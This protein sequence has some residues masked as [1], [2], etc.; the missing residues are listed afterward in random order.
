MSPTYLINGIVISQAT[1][2]LV[3][4][5][6][7]GDVSVRVTPQTRIGTA[8]SPATVSVSNQVQVRIAKDT[9]GAS[10]ALSIEVEPDVV[11]I[12]GVVQTIGA[13]TLTVRNAKGDTT[14]ALD[15]D[16]IVV[17]GG[18]VATAAGL[19]VGDTVEVHG[20]RRADGSVLA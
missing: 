11:E 17:V 8:S 14:V 2:Q 3:V 15:D 10:V 9:R 16:T 6:L 7:R 20:L 5:T 18:A 4:R 19:V 12:E 1:S 13:T